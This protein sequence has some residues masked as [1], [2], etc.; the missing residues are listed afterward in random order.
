MDL[1]ITLKS[2]LW[3][4]T[5]LL[6]T[7]CGEPVADINKTNSFNKHG[8]TFKYPGNWTLSDEVTGDIISIYLETPGDTV[9]IIQNYPNDY[10]MNLKEFSED[11]RKSMIENLPIGN[12]NSQKVLSSSANMIDEEFSISLVGEKVPHRRKFLCLNSEKTTCFL[13][14]QVPKEDYEKSQKGFELIHSSLELK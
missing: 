2:A 8:M 13:I 5:L 7:G 6:I 9:V 11:F 3:L 12:I 10:S 4:C 14:Y 1:S